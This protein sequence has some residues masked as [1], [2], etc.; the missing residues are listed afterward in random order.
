[1]AAAELV[2]LRDA[3]HLEPGEAFALTSEWR[4]TYEDADDESLEDAVLYE[5]S[6]PAV[7]VAEAPAEEQP[8]PQGRV[9]LV[10]A[11]PLRAVQAVFVRSGE[12]YLWHGPSELDA[13][14]AAIAG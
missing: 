11:V 10:G 9:T 6:S 14:I 2:R 4:G 7:V 1:M 5:R 13:A 8:G 12:D 3:G